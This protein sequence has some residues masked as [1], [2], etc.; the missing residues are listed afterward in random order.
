MG[1]L[2]CQSDF[3]NTKTWSFVCLRIHRA[4]DVVRLTWSVFVQ[5]SSILH[6][7]AK[8]TNRKQ[9][10][11]RNPN[12]VASGKF[13]HYQ[14]A[15]MTFP[16]NSLSWGW[17][18]IKLLRQTTISHVWITCNTLL[19]S[20]NLPLTDGAARS[21]RLCFLIQ[22]TTFK[23]IVQAQLY[24]FLLW[25]L[26]QLVLCLE[27]LLSLHYVFPLVVFAVVTKMSCFMVH[28]LLLAMFIK[29]WYA[30]TCIRTY[31]RE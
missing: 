18:Y 7:S 23:K 3:L 19:R 29:I 14:D 6:P 11:I 15:W 31:I 24:N 22:I 26:C 20:W 12:R 28:C 9:R 27:A 5:K 17:A 25:R 8:T 21:T 4:R 1:L 13:E 2:W 30:I 10:D 16:H